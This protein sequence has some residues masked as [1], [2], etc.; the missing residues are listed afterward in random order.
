MKLY[1]PYNRKFGITM[2]QVIENFCHQG[3]HHEL[4]AYCTVRGRRFRFRQK[5]FTTEIMDGHKVG[6]YELTG[7]YVLAAAGPL[8]SIN[9]KMIQGVV[10]RDILSEFIRDTLRTWFNKEVEREHFCV[11]PPLK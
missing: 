4:F 8:V 7:Y 5:E 11:Y 6:G 3:I 9:Y 2:E 10:D 1:E